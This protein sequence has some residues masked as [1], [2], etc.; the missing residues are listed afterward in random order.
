MASKTSG[1]FNVG[2]GA[3]NSFN[4]VVAELNRVLGTNLP[5]E[6]FENPYAFFQTW[7]E[8]DLT[9]SRKVLGYNPTIDLAKGID[10]YYESGQL[11]A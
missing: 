2:S 10:A 9:E 1:V 11:G 4:R 5:P 7:T 8:A 6:Y 3:A